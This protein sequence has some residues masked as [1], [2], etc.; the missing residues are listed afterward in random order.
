MLYGKNKLCESIFKILTAFALT[1]MQLTLLISSIFTFAE[2]KLATDQPYIQTLLQKNKRKIWDHACLQTSTRQV[3]LEGYHKLGG[4]LTCATN[5]L[6]GR[7]R[8]TF[9]DPY[10]RW[11]GIELMGRSSD[12][13]LVLLTVYQV[14]QKSGPYGSTTAYSQQRNMFRLEGRSDPNPRHIS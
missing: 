9:S 3:I 8:H 10:G 6:V 2:T 4:T 1:M 12:K 14:T 11:S 13:Y 5:N 7:V